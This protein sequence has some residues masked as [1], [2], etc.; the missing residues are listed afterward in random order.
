V[1][2]L[3]DIGEIVKAA[4]SASAKELYKD[5]AHPALSRL[6]RALGSALD[7][8][9][10]PV[11]LAAYPAQRVLLILRANLKRLSE[12]LMRI[13]EAK[14]QQAANEIAVPALQKLSFVDD[15]SIRQMYIEL[16]G[17]ASD[18]TLD[19]VAHPSFLRVIESLSPDE[20]RILPYYRDHLSIPCIYFRIV[21]VQTPL[22]GG[23][24][25]PFSVEGI[26]ATPDL[27]GIERA[28]ELRF[29]Q[30]MPLYL[31]NDV[32][33]GLLVRQDNPL[34]DKEKYY[35]PLEDMYAG[36]REALHKRGHGGRQYPLMT[37]QRH[38]NV[39]PF[40]QAFINAVTA[41]EEAPPAAPGAS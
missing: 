9:L 2:D 11:H 33:L 36:L 28:I 5:I 27:T 12:R 15:D 39:T 4:A 31:T 38:F 21:F 41:P 18:S 29:P 16:L 32:A 22:E 30:N 37:V 13:D 19:S 14:V 8:T 40:G 3:P 6:G 7:L 10:L 17:K 20:A 23:Q 26:D 35:A 25:A 1:S 34:S 24:A